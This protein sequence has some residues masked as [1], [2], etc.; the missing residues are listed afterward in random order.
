MFFCTLYQC[1]SARVQ[2]RVCVT[3]ARERRTRIYLPMTLQL[4]SNATY[5]LLWALTRLRW[6]DMSVELESLIDL[7]V[8]FQIMEYL[9]DVTL[10]FVVEF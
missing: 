2:L 6:S 7:L 9:R 4:L 10:I 1:A 3:A 8:H 5:K